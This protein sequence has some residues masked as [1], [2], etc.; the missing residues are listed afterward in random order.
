M[1]LVYVKKVNLM[2]FKL[3]LVYLVIIFANLAKLI[4]NFAPN[5]IIKMSTKDQ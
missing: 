4:V 3:K 2:I 5:V 1:A